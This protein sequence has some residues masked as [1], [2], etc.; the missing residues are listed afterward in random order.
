MLIG[1]IFI[2]LLAGCGALAGIVIGRAMYQSPII[3][4]DL[5]ETADCQ[6]PCWMHI[7]PG[8]TSFIVANDL[9]LQAGYNG[10]ERPFNGEVKYTPPTLTRC[11]VRLFVLNDTVNRLRLIN[12]QPTH[13]GDV[14][15]ILGQPEGVISDRFAMAFRGGKVLIYVQRILCE[16]RFAPDTL[17]GT[18]DFL[19]DTQP[20]YSIY[21]WQGFFVDLRRY[22]W[23]N[24]VSVEC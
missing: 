16:K 19:N 7:I 4:I 9:I 13:L 12:C 1:V 6:Y 8:K 5:H 18:I 3:T 23:R 14:I 10:G 21:P 22:M 24:S 2:T 17:V 11:E 20:T 15:E